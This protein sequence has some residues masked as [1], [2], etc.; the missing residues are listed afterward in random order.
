MSAYFVRGSFTVWPGQRSRPVAVT[1]RVERSKC[2]YFV[3]GSLRLVRGSLRLGNFERILRNGTQRWFRP[4]LFL[5]DLVAAD[6]EFFVVVFGNQIE[7]VGEACVELLGTILAL[8]DGLVV[9]ILLAAILG[10]DPFAFGFECLLGFGPLD[11]ARGLLAGFGR[12]RSFVRGLLLPGCRRV[13]FCR[14]GLLLVGLLIPGLAILRFL[15]V[16]LFFVRF[17]LIYLVGRRSVG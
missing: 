3:R 2:A 7:P 14:V 12:F 9:L 17:L 4:R 11:V 8:L 1:A 6:V 5:D 13:G 10:L 15:V 16:G